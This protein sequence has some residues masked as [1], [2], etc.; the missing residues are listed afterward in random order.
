MNVFDDL[1]DYLSD[2]DLSIEY[3]IAKQRHSKRN[4]NTR[5]LNKQLQVTNINKKM[6]ERQ[7]KMLIDEKNHLTRE[8]LLSGDRNNP[9]KSASCSNIFQNA[10]ESPDTCQP[11]DELKN[12]KNAE[13]VE[14]RQNSVKWGTGK[15]V[16]EE[17]SH[18][19]EQHKDLL[20]KNKHE[21]DVAVRKINTTLNASSSISAGAMPANNASTFNGKMRRHSSNPVTN[22]KTSF[23]TTNL[24]GNSKIV[25]G[26]S[27][28]NNNESPSKCFPYQ[29]EY[30][31]NSLKRRK[32]LKTAWG[33]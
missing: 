1:K 31:T 7:G 28:D 23:Q 3:Q 19:V 15:M 17:S 27:L 2:S 26:N 4:K 25:N 22:H 18:R 21:N 12:K 5:N 6:M 10:F 13:V 33:R 8:K 24:L 11:S 20:L 32:E 30:C 16:N 29:N 14:N 9:F